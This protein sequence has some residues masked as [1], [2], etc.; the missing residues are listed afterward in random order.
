VICLGSMKE[1][2]LPE[3]GIIGNF[4]LPDG[5]AATLAP[6]LAAAKLS[7]FLSV[8]RGQDAVAF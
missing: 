6:G 4:V 1:L 8:R 5:E 7:P 2:T 3:N